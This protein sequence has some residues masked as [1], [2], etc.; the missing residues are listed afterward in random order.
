MLWA[1]HTRMR[2]SVQPGLEPE[3]FLYWARHRYPKS[4]FL[5]HN[6]ISTIQLHLTCSRNGIKSDKGEETSGGSGEHFWHTEWHET[7][8]IDLQLSI[9]PTDMK[10]M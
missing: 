4:C 6:S 3:M 2:S 7:A 5:I 10:E 8:I 1:A 9:L